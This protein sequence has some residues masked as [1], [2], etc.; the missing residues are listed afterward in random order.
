MHNT[1]FKDT[2]PQRESEGE[3]ERRGVQIETN[4]EGKKS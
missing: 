1:R 2:F 4:E 3:R